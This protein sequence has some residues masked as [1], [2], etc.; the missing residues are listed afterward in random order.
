MRTTKKRAL[1]DPAALQTKAQIAAEEMIREI[2]HSSAMD[3]FGALLDAAGALPPLPHYEKDEPFEIRCQR[4]DQALEACSHIIDDAAEQF[5]R[6][7]TESG[8]VARAMMHAIRGTPT[9]GLY[10]VV[11]PAAN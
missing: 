4:E 7:L 6:H 8:E 10:P 3:S 1:S 11:D 2:M 5:A 9:V